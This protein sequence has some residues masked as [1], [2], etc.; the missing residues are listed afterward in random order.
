MWQ[1]NYDNKLVWR[2]E[3]WINDSYHNIINYTPSKPSFM[4]NSYKTKVK[5]WE[6]EESNFDFFALK[7]RLWFNPIKF[8]ERDQQEENLIEQTDQEDREVTDVAILDWY[9]YLFVVT[10]DRQKMRVYKQIWVTPTSC[11]DK[12]TTDIRAGNYVN[13]TKYDYEY[14]WSSYTKDYFPFD[15]CVSDKFVKS[16]W[17]KWSPISEWNCSLSNNI[18]WNELVTTFFSDDVISCSAGDYVFIYDWTYWWQVADCLVNNWNSVIIW[19]WRAWMYNVWKPITKTNISD[20]WDI[21]DEITT[22]EWA[23][24]EVSSWHKYKIFKSYS[25]ILNFATL[26]GIFHL[27]NDEWR[28]STFEVTY[29]KY[30][31]TVTNSG[32]FE[33]I[34][35]VMS[36]IHYDSNIFF[37]ERNNWIL[38][39]WLYWYNK[40]YFTSSNSKELVSS[41]TDMLKF[42]WYIVL[43]GP[44]HVWVFNAIYKDQ[45]ILDFAYFMLSDKKWYFSRDSFDVESGN[46]AIYTN[47]KKLYTLSLEYVWNVTSD[48]DLSK[49]FQFNPVWWFNYMP[50]WGE[51]DML[52]S[53]KDDVSLSYEDWELRIMVSPKYNE[54]N[55]VWTKI[56]QTDLKNKFQYTWI[57]KWIKVSWF[58]NW[59]RYW[60]DLYYLEWD[61]DNWEYFKTSISMF[62]GEQTLFSPK[63]IDYMRLGIWS[64]SYITNWNTKMIIDIMM[65]DWKNQFVY[66]QLWTTNY[67][68]Y[69]MKAKDHWEWE[70]IY[71]MPIDIEV[72]W[73]NWVWED[74]ETNF[75]LDQVLNDRFDYSKSSS[76]ISEKSTSLHVNK[77]WILQFWID[78]VCSSVHTELLTEWKDSIEFLWIL[79]SSDYIEWFAVKPDNNV[80]IKD[81]SYSWPSNKTLTNWPSAWK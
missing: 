67:V 20:V 80:I 50:E 10:K 7:K 29:N 66:D 75:S 48:A 56:Y 35:R 1:N 57:I 6:L 60:E 34:K 42:Q 26:D 63:Y 9:R 22:V 41:Y 12:P 3:I 28:P 77:Y 70:T 55:C 23:T 65:D 32:T 43:L 47:T 27:H 5:I 52:D 81:R 73:W 30:T 44:S 68:K 37:L 76:W 59:I 8:Y 54:W 79:I 33:P 25:Q 11:W 15:K 49:W 4:N 74:L 40:F 18:V 61:K 2:G 13:I 69:I 38:S 72:M 46:L 21:I 78:S 58:K 62:F 19:W 36:F 71:D 64:D 14:D 53:E 39:W 16:D 51:M 31:H 24:E 45:W 17:V